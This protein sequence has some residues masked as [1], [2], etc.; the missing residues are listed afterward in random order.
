M[1]AFSDTLGRAVEDPAGLARR[2]IAGVPPQP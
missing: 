2:L 1:V